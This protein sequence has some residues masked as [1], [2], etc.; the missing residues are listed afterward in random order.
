ML[1][2]DSLVRKG[3]VVRCFIPGVVRDAAGAW[4]RLP[5]A[6]FSLV[7]MEDPLP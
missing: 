3:G 4:P 2:A 7:G 5:G 6:L 1:S